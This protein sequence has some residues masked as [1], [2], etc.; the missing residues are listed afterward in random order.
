M[1]LTI[2]DR[3]AALALRN[4]RSAITDDGRGQPTKRFSTRPFGTAISTAMVGSCRQALRQSALWFSVWRER[5]RRTLDRL[6][7][8]PQRHFVVLRVLFDFRT[9]G[10]GRLLHCCFVGLLCCLS[11]CWT[12]RSPHAMTVASVLYI[13]HCPIAHKCPTSRHGSKVPT[14][15]VKTSKPPRDPAFIYGLGATSHPN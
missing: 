13:Y 6:V 11:E 10:R 1:G 5:P 15:E 3:L 2:R 4:M 8:R 9:A 12:Q 7:L 14:T